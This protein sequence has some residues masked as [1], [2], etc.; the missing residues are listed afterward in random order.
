MAE[1]APGFFGKAPAFG[2][3]LSR[4]MPTV[5][6]PAWDAWLQA[7]MTDSRARLKGDWLSAWLGMP[8]W[9][10]G[11]GPGLIGPGRAF[12]VLIPSVDRVGR[13]F[14]FSI[15]GQAAPGG[16][17]LVDWALRVEA[18]ALDALEDGFDPARLQSDLAILGAPAEPAGPKT[19]PIF[20]WKPLDEIADW[21]PEIE[22]ALAGLTD[23]ETLFWCRGAGRVVGSM[24]RSA[25]LPAEQQAAVLVAGGA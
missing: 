6:L 23:G 8:V 25:G 22:P 3:F 9:H 15:L 4:G 1:P 16:A 7:V 2:D 18:L 14:P 5:F 21:P 12:G 10:F 24:L 19:A 11:F 17:T 13:H 20:G